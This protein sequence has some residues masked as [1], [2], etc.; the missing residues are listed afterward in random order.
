VKAGFA[1]VAAGVAGLT[2]AARLVGFGRSL[3]FSKTV[4]DTCL[5]DTYNAANSLPAWWFRSL[6][7]TSERA[8]MSTHPAPPQ[9]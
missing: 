4:G 8:E 6:R 3:V 1:S 7:V 9:P 2:L 5:G